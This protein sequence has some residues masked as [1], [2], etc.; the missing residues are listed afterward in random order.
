[1]LLIWVIH[2]LMHFCMFVY[3]IC[4]EFTEV[5]CVVHKQQ[6]MFV[7]YMFC[8]IGYLRNAILYWNDCFL[9]TCS[10]ICELAEPGCSEV[11]CHIKKNYDL[12]ILHVHTPWSLMIS[13]TKSFMLHI[14][15]L[16]QCRTFTWC[17]QR[18]LERKILDDK[19]L[20]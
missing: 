6:L 5:G 16:V 12:K 18:I 11:K 9:Q 14:F 3:P 1:M 17:R 8:I 7:F 20:T 15:W 4:V 19:C 13:H 2:N 10:K